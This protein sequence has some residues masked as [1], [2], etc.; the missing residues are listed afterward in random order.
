MLYDEED[1]SDMKIVESGNSVAI[2]NDDAITRPKSAYQYH[3]QIRCPVIKANLLAE[4]KN[5]SM[6]IVVQTVASMW[7]AMS[8]ED[9]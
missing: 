7:R 8:N 1:F 2:N 3:S 6:G 5:A 4:G 9:K